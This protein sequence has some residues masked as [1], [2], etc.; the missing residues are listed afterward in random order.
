MCGSGS[1]FVVMGRIVHHLGWVQVP[2]TSMPSGSSSD[3]LGTRH[4]QLGS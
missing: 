3:F 1:S 4:P 2:L